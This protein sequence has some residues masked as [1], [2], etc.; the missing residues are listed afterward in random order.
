MAGRGHKNIYAVY[1]GDEYITEG[2]KEEL[3]EKLNVK[4]ETISFMASP[5]MQK[6]DK[7]NR[8]RVF[9]IEDEEEL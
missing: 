3:A 1:K 8:T 6:R 9:L 4:L 5:T 7:G 2:T